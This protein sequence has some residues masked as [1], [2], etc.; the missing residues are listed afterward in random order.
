MFFT[1]LNF[2]T[3]LCTKNADSKASFLIRGVGAATTFFEWGGILQGFWES[4]IFDD[5]IYQVPPLPRVRGIHSM[6]CHITPPPSPTFLRMGALL[7]STPLFGYQGLARYRAIFFNE[8][9]SP[10]ITADAHALCVTAPHGGKPPGPGQQTPTSCPL[11][12][13][14]VTW[15]KAA[16]I[17]VLKFLR[18]PPEPGDGGYL[19]VS[20]LGVF[21]GSGRGVVQH[22]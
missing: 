15:T 14:G 2:P 1:G 8:I 11:S 7:G 17:M 20:C 21:S 19:A 6:R 4:G 5:G 3:T 16:Q 12:S 9:P 10:A 13:H 22:P 18:A